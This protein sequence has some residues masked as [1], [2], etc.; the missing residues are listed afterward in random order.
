MQ[1]RTYRK[2]RMNRGKGGSLIIFILH[3][4]FEG[5]IVQMTEDVGVIRAT[6][7]PGNLKDLD[8]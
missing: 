1:N 6:K 2:V 3:I 7:K 8:S 4:L 5:I